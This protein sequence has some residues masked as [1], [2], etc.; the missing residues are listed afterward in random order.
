M[1]SDN[2]RKPDR[3]APNSKMSPIRWGAGKRASAYVRMAF[4]LV[5]WTA[6]RGAWSI[7][8]VKRARVRGDDERGQQVGT[9]A[10]PKT[11]GTTEPNKHH[12]QLREDGG[13][14]RHNKSV[15]KE[16][17]IKAAPN[18]WFIYEPFIYEI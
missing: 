17:F 1:Y 18:S 6:G 10:V 14:V 13:R 16:A 2:T 4:T 3:G 15:D 12:V 7:A 8:S 11:G 5:L 9:L